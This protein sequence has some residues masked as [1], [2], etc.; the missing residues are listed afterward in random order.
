MSEETGLQIEKI[1]VRGSGSVLNYS[2]D[3][4]VVS[5]SVNDDTRSKNVTSSLSI[6]LDEVC[7]GFNIQVPER[8]ESI[9]DVKHIIITFKGHQELLA[10]LKSLSAI[11][12]KTNQTQ[13]LKTL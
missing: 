10:L 5:L 8:Q 1:E 3:D 11:I 12:E 9:K 7:Y 2:D 4:V 13:G 6:S